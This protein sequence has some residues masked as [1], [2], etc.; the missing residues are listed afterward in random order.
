MLTHS[1]LR[2]KPPKSTGREEFGKKFIEKLLQRVRKV[3]SEDIVATASFFTPLV[4]HEAYTK[5]IG[6]NFKVDEFI[7]SG[8]GS[9]NNYIVETLLA[10]FGEG[11]VKFSDQFGVSSQAKEAI[12]FALLANETIAGGTGNLPSV[13]G[14]RQA[15]V[16]GKICKP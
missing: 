3:R 12:C 1:Y 2:K 10:L 8:G 11:A 14:A 13:T 9:R 5:F 6:S 4:V 7:L 15:V 16:L